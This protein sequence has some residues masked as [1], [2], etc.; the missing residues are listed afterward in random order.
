MVL[1]LSFFGY[2]CSRLVRRIDVRRTSSQEQAENAQ[3]QPLSRMQRIGLL[4]G[5]AKPAYRTVV[6]LGALLSALRLVLRTSLLRKNARARDL[7][8]HV[9]TGAHTSGRV[10]VNAGDRSVRRPHVGGLESCLAFR[11]EFDAFGRDHV[12][13]IGVHGQLWLD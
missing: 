6:F 1:G 11:G 12:I 13:V 8:G 10:Y 7:V 4:V 3:E 2:S 5:N 9:L